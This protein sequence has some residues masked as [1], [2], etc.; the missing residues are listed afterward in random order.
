MHILNITF[1]DITG[2]KAQSPHTMLYFEQP[3]WLKA[4]NIV[5]AEYLQFVCR[6]GG[7]HTLMSFLGA[8]AH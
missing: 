7:F 2:E 3:L 4:F 5:H 8:L 1:C 6:L